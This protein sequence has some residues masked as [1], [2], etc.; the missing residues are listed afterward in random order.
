VKANRIIITDSTLRDGEQTPGI[1]FTLEEKIAIALALERAGV[2][3]IE[4]G[5]PAMGDDEIAA[6]AEV[7][8]HLTHA[9]AMCWGRM[10]RSDVD[11]ALRTGL[12]RVSL[13]VPMSDV[14]IKVKMQGR[15]DLVKSRIREV[16]PY[17]LDRG[18]EVV[19]GGEDSSR[20][21]L[22]FLREALNE[23]EE[24]GV[25]RFR[26]ADTTGTLDPFW[27]RA[28]FER[29]CRDTELALEFHGHDDLGLATANTLAAVT[30]GATWASVCVLG[31]G[32]RAGN[33]ALEEVATALHRVT[34]CKTN[35]KFE[36]LPELADLVS[37]ASRRPI[38][39]NKPIVGEAVFSHESGIHVAGL[40]KNPETYE[41]LSPGLFGRERQLV[42][43]KHSGRS[44]V[45]NALRSLG[46]SHEECCV[47]KVL[48]KV[49]EFSATRKRAVT[50]EELRQFHLE[51]TS[52]TVESGMPGATAATLAARH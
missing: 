16:V 12:T 42:L 40:L 25:S 50:V 9:V 14:M 49:R 22:E 31:L 30:G 37:R 33:A 24:A 45:I 1:A 39:S 27:T 2:D 23:A 51:V 35:I 46:L 17:A 13:S 7:G 44:A 38:P 36:H 4:V 20:A 5:I 26:F 43:G 29:L 3:E 47:E 11:A 41:A 19:M 34:T 21:S 15:R 48:Q 32:E 10:T 28:I 8:K 18:L 6:I 52:A